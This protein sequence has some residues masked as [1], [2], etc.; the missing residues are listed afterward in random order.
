[1]QQ[2]DEGADEYVAWSSYNAAQGDGDLALAQ[3]F[4]ISF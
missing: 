3:E 4:G 1:M 2:R